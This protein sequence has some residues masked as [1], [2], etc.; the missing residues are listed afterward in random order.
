MPEREE[1]LLFGV[2]GVGAG[3]QSCRLRVVLPTGWRAENQKADRERDECD[4]GNASTHVHGLP[5][6]RPV[7]ATGS[8]PEPA[9]RRR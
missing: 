2:A 3:A 8:L 1:E 9:G 6:T 4:H 5:M 7:P